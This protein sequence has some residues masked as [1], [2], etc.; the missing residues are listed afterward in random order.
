MSIRPAGETDLDVICHLH[1]KAFG[2]EEGPQIA[3]LVH[4]L[5]S[6]ETAQPVYSLVAEA[7]GEIAGHV[8]FTAV[9]V[10]GAPVRAQILAPLAILP[11]HQKRGIGGALIRDG[12]R[13][14]SEA[15]VGLVF[16]LGHPSYYPR[17]GFE[18]VGD[19][20]LAAP[21]PIPPEHEEGWMVQALKPGLLGEVR[22]TVLCA[23]SLDRAEYW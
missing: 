1:R 4:A 17:F 14:L 8:L 2:E 23:D 12:L 10:E 5:L 6:D 9:Q 20:G 16:V 13:R 15:G 11:S 3:E 22:G 18:A 7:N 21:Y 19:R